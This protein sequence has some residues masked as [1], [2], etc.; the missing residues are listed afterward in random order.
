MRVHHPYCTCGVRM[1]ATRAPREGLPFSCTRVGGAA[2]RD[3]KTQLYL[4]R[5]TFI[6]GVAMLY[7]PPQTG[8]NTYGWGELE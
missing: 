1:G 5:H 6:N 7:S 4:R 8:D 3:G 2:R